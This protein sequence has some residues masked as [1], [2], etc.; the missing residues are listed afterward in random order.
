M[1][2]AAPEL[3]ADRPPLTAALHEWVVTVDHKKIGIMYVV[4]AIAFLLLAGLEAVLIRMQLFFPRLDFL[5]PLTFN[6]STSTVPLNRDGSFGRRT[7]IR[8]RYS[9]VAATVAAPSPSSA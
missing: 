3:T 4:M 7:R 5:P 1:A 8:L 2:T 9:A 6:H